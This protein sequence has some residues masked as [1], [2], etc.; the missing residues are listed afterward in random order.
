MD[1]ARL[2][3]V[4][5][6]STA[7]DPAGP[8]PFLYTPP[9]MP[10]GLIKLRS[11]S[12]SSKEKCSR[13]TISSRSP[14]L[15]SASWIFKN[16]MNKPLPHSNRLTLARIFTNCWQSY[17]PKQRPPRP[18]KIRHRNSVLLHL[19][20]LAGRR[21]GDCCMPFPM[22]TSPRSKKGREDTDGT[23]TRPHD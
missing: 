18:E 3:A 1:K 7:F 17:N 12:R 9:F 2:I 8:T 14:T 23:V 20:R 4:R 13:P 16:A 22:M 19:A 6:Q 21:Y 15:S 5:R 10:A 11:I